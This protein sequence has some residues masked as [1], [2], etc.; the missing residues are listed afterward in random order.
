MN[1]KSVPTSQGL[2]SVKES[3]EDHRQPSERDVK[4]DG[5]RAKP[6]SP[7]QNTGEEAQVSPENAD[8]QIKASQPVD[9]QTAADLLNHSPS[10]QPRQKN[11]FSAVARST[12]PLPNVKK[13][14]RAA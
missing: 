7:P 14:N 10:P 11:R 9:S 8:Q 12:K 6:A 1:I 4:K 2:N 13:L 5:K 3:A